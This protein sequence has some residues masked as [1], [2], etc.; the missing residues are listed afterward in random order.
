MNDDAKGHLQMLR[1]RVT[2]LE[3]LLEDLLAYSRAGRQRVEI[4]TVDVSVMIQRVAEDLN[5]VDSMT[6]K[7][8][9]DFPAIPSPKAPLEHVFINL[10]ANAAKHNDL[11]QGNIEVSA[12]IDGTG[13]RF[14]VCDD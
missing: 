4:E 8:V 13:Y 1:K 10:I 3:T 7:F 6:V 5:L 9:S 14:K 2:R 11:D 12:Q